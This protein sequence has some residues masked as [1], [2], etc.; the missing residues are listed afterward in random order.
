MAHA[1]ALQAAVEKIVADAFPLRQLNVTAVNGDGTVDLA[2]AAGDITD[3]SCA[4]SYG[5][6]TVGDKVVVVRFP[7]GSWEVLARSEAPDPTP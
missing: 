7:S 6:R 2:G 4:S 5:H 1:D 3:V